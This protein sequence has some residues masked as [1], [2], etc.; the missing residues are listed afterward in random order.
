MLTD[1]TALRLIH[2]YL[3]LRKQRTRVNY[4]YSEWLAVMFGVTQGSVLGLLLFNIFLADLFLIHSDID[5]ANFADDN[6]P[7]LSAENV[8]DAIKSLE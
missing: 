8:E 2:D 7:Y 6:T 1:L 5:T 4:S 3:S